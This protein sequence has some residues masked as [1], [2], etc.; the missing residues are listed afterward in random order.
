[1][2]F[3]RPGSGKSATGWR[4]QS[5][6]EPSAC[7]VELPSKFQTGSSSSVGSSES[8]TIFVLLR[9]FATGSYPSSPMYSA[10]TFDMCA[11]LSSR[12][13]KKA[14][15]TGSVVKRHCFRGGLRRPARAFNLAVPSD[16][17][18]PP[19]PAENLSRDLPDRPVRVHVE[20][21]PVA[22]AALP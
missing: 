6:F 17:R 15:T 16:G 19:G 22:H 9:R 7:C 4:R 20:G 8:S 12:T 21:R 5:E 18:Q 13:T 2:A 14:P 3:A 11:F 1:T 10:F